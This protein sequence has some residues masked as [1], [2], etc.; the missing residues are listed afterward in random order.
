MATTDKVFTFA[1]AD[2]RVADVVR[3]RIAPVVMPRLIGFEFAREFLF[4][5]VSQIMLN[6]REGPLSAGTAGQVHG[7]DRLPWG[8]W[9]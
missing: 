9:R 3:T 4:R 8:R 1:T 2:G 7:G 5:T 6:Y